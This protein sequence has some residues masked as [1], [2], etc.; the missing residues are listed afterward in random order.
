MTGHRPQAVDRRGAAVEGQVLEGDPFVARPIG[1]E[2]DAGRSS[3]TRCCGPRWAAGAATVPAIRSPA[4]RARRRAPPSRRGDR[5]TARWPAPRGRRHPRRRGRRALRAARPPAPRPGPARVPGCRRTAAVSTGG[6]EDG[7][8]PRPLAAARWPTPLDEG[9]QPECGEDGDHE[10]EDRAVCALRSSLRSPGAAVAAPVGRRPRTPPNRSRASRRS[11][12]RGRPAAWRA[13]GGARRL[14]PPGRPSSLRRTRWSRPG[15]RHRSTGRRGLRSTGR[16]PSGATVVSNV[17]RPSLSCGFWARDSVPR[18]RSRSAK[19]ISTAA[20]TQRAGHDAAPARA[21]QCQRR[22][23][24]SA[25]ASGP[26]AR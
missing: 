24:A 4:G 8:R 17:S 22:A 7:A 14:Q 1:Q 6:A 26:R 2:V 10:A 25:G 9:L 18:N 5:P 13:G 16:A 23:A 21:E 3:G 19:G 15:C 12:P 20:T 11:A